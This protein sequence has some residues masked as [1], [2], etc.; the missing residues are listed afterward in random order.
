MD[1]TE[2]GA[3]VGSTEMLVSPGLLPINVMV[4]LTR[5]VGSLPM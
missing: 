2:P 1:A 5:P 4:T 3:R